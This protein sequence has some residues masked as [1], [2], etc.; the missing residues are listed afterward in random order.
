[1]RGAV[2]A[3]RAQGL[4]DVCVEAG[5]SS[6]LA[7]YDAPVVVDE[8]LLSVYAEEALAPDLIAGPF[9]AWRDLEQVFG[10][11]R[12]DV[13]RIEESGRWRFLRYC[14]PRLGEVP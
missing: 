7:V 13:S 10:A 14:R 3:L 5:P 4:V 8:L 6:A 9:P 1:M 12:S 11:A 2:I